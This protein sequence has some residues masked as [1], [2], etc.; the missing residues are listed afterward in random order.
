M[1]D[2]LDQLLARIRRRYEE[3][4]GGSDARKMSFLA[5]VRSLGRWESDCDYHP[6]PG[7]ADFPESLPIAFA[8]CDPECGRSEF[9]VEG[10]TQECQHC[11]SLMYRT[12]TMEYRLV[13]GN[14]SPDQG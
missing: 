14:A 3:L 6:D 10:S 13:S 5:H 4:E 1:S 11:G 12:E 9:I 2:N 8:V 7:K